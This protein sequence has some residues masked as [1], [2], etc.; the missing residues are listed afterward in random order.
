M[1]ICFKG[2]SN[3]NNIAI[4]FDDGP[5]L[6][7]TPQLLKVLDENRAKGT[8]FLT[9]SNAIKHKNLVLEILSQGHQIANHS[10][11]HHKSLISTPGK[12]MC[13]IRTTQEIL[14]DITG[15]TIS[16]YRPP[17]GYISPFLFSVCKKLN[18]KIILWSVHSHD[19]RREHYSVIIK[20]ILK[21][22]KSG[23]IVLFHECHHA[24]SSL[25]YS[26]TARAVDILLKTKA[27]EE[28]NFVTVTQLLSI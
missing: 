19:Y 6:R 26:N 11:N 4:T 27:S 14:E 24:K 16:L 18:L 7:Y 12:L 8:F 25:D 23:S 5:H 20:R 22:V 15:S 1:N 13:Q 9:G 2:P 17:F 28:F 3:F 10:L 21:R